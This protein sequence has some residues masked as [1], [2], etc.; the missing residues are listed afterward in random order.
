MVIMQ[1]MYHII[2]YDIWFYISHILLHIPYVYQRV[3]KIHHETPYE[4]MTY[5][6]TN[7]GHWIETLVQPIGFLLPFLSHSNRLWMPCL[8]AAIIIGS[9]GLMRHDHRFTIVV[10]SHHLMHHRYPQYNY[11][12]Y[13]L[14]WL[15]G[16]CYCNR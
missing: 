13:W 3:H 4:K 8:Y 6:D 9:R 11:G 2:C 14:D 10:G 16:T 5:K 15:C 7:R 12:E 1:V